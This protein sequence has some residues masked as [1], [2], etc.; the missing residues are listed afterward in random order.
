MEGEFSDLPGSGVRGVGPLPLP[1]A[2]ELNH[3][4]IPT[5]N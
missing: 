5:E 4:R 2:S 1:K 3:Q